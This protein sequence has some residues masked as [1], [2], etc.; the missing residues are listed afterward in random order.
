MQICIFHSSCFFSV[1][2]FSIRFCWLGIG[3]NGKKLPS[4][5]TVHSEASKFAVM[6]QESEK[7][8]KMREA[9]ANIKYTLKIIEKIL[10]S[11]V[12][13]SSGFFNYRYFLMICLSFFSFS[14]SFL[15]FLK[16]SVRF[17]YF[18]LKNNRFELVES[19]KNIKNTYKSR[20]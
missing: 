2:S 18:C 15:L 3:D 8:V 12:L 10:D 13:L 1:K 5:T 6:H 9:I 7:L 16:I 19:T 20:K 4:S 14:I 11:E 17:D